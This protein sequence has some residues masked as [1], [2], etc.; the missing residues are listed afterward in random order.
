MVW[1][2]RLELRT[3]SVVDHL[4]KHLQMFWKILNHLIFPL[5]AGLLGKKTSQGAGFRMLVEDVL[6]DIVRR[7]GTGP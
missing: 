3:F 5:R 6:S 7:I 1:T 4:L 2:I